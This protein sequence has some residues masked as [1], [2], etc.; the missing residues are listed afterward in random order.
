MPKIVFNI[1][2]TRKHIFKT[3]NSFNTMTVQRLP[4]PTK[5]C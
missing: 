3:G 1:G 5:I 2:S 4:K